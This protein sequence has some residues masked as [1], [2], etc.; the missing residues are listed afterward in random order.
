[1]P[2]GVLRRC[3]AR[4]AGPIRPN[5]KKKVREREAHESRVDT[6][7]FSAGM[8][9]DPMRKRAFARIST[10]VTG[11]RASQAM[12]R[13]RRSESASNDGGTGRDVIGQGLLEKQKS[14]AAVSELARRLDRS[15]YSARL[16]PALTAAVGVCL[17]AD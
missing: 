9:S 4:R 3:F 1:M 10:D 8:S 13:T 11:D 17:S 14:T 2:P 15:V 12:R 5:S 16:F 6:T 7:A